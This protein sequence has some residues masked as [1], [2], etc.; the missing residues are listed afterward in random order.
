LGQRAQ[1]EHNRILANLE[2]GADAAV[3]APMLAPRRGRVGVL[4]AIILPLGAPACLSY[5]MATLSG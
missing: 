3:R 1:G 5:H 4:S 2:H